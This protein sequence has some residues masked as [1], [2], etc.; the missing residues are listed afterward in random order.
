MDDK[1]F[2]DVIAV[3]CQPG[4]ED[5]TAD[6]GEGLS[7][8]LATLSPDDIV[9]FGWWFDQK[10]DALYTIDHWG[11]AYRINGGASDDGFFYWRCWVVGMGKQVYE[12]ALAD[13]DSLADVVDPKV[14]DYEA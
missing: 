5:F 6:W 9:R 8:Q 4:V 2:W 13:P 3:A 10:T 7:K 12:A 1:R 14:F 11:A